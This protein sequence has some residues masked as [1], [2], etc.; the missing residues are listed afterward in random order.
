MKP[1]PRLLAL[2]IAA[3]AAA[4]E[5]VPEYVVAP[6]P[7]N[8]VKD[9]ATALLVDL[10]TPKA[11]ADFSAGSPGLGLE[12][13]RFLKEGG[14]RGPIAVPVPKVLDG[15]AWTIEMVMRA[16]PEA[17]A[18]GGAVALGGWA[19]KGGFSLGFA[20]PPHAGPGFTL[21][22]PARAGGRAHPFQFRAASGGSTYTLAKDAPGRWVYATFG[23]DLEGRRGSAMVRSLDGHV[24]NRNM[25][26]CG[27]GSLSEEFLQR[28]P[29]GER[30]SARD[31]CWQGMRDA[32]GAG[33]PSSFPLGGEKIDLRA[34]R[35]SRRFRPEVAL[36][37]P[38]FQQAEGEPLRASEIDAARAAK[39]RP[40]RSVGYNDHNLVTLPIEESWIP[41]APGQQVVLPPRKLP[42]GI[43]SWWLYGAVDPK[44]RKEIGRV[45]QP[46]PMEFEVKDGAGKKVGGGRLL[47][48]QSFSPRFMQAFSFHV[49]EPGEFTATLRLAERSMETVLLH[50]ANFVDVLKGV[51]DQAIKA[52]QLLAE[53]RGDRLKEL[54]EARKQ[55]DDA[56]WAA[57]PPLNTHTLA[58][59]PPIWR[60]LPDGAKVPD[61]SF[62]AWVGKRYPKLEDALAPM[63]LVDPAS[64]ASLPA[65]QVVAGAPL[66]GPLGD[67]GTGIFLRKAEHPSLAQDMYWCPRAALMCRR[68]EVL[69]R[70]I[71]PQNGQDG[72]RKYFETGD[73]E[74]GHDVAMLLVRFAYD[75][76]ALEYGSQDIRLCT[77]DKDLE[78]NQHWSYGRGGKV[79]NWSWSAGDAHD[80]IEAYDRVFPYIQDNALFA[81]E[82][83]RFIP[84]VKTPQDVVRLLDRQ[85]VLASV[86][87]ERR[88][89]LAT[90]RE[91]TDA[92]GEV[93][94]PGPLTADLFDLSTQASHLFPFRGPFADGYA[95]G[96]SRSG[97]YYAGSFLAYAL[98]S[99]KQTVAKA[100]SMLAL[101]RLGIAPRMDLSDADKFPKVRGAAN[102]ILGMWV[103][104]GFPCAVGDASG[105]PHAGRVAW[106]AID[107]ATVEKAFAVLGDP[108]Y[109]WILKNRF[110]SADPAAAKAAE[111]QRDPI[112]HAPSRVI[113]DYEAFLEATPD[114]A[115]P[116]RKVG[117]SLRLG[118]GRAHTHED[119]LDVN[120]WA[121]GVP[122][123]VDLACRN[124]GTSTWSRPSATWSF[125][126]NHAIATEDQDP[127]AAAAQD[128]EP[129][130]RA[131]APPLARAS[132]VNGKGTVS[133]DRDLCLVQVGDG[134][135]WYAFDFQR[136]K[137]L[138]LHTWCF[139]GCESE[140]LQLNVP[141]ED[142]TV[143]WVDRTLE[144]THKVG[145]ATDA[146]QATWTMTR[147]AREVPHKFGERGGGTI[148]AVACEPA[149][150]GDRYD[151]KL[152][153]VRMRATLLGRAGD[154]VL[155]GSPFSEF[156]QYCFPFLWVQG[157]AKGESVYPAVYEWY[158]GDA[159]TVAKAEILSPVGGAARAESAAVPWTVRVTTSSGQ[160]DEFT[161]TGAG[162]AAV[163]RDAKGGLRWA[164]LNGLAEFASGDLKVKAAAAQHSTTIA[165]VDYAKRRLVTKDPLPENPGVRV[166]NSSRWC[167]LQLKG[168]GTE[169]SW[170]DDLLIAQGALN[171]VKVTGPDRA[172]ID[173]ENPVMFA[174]AGN[175]KASAFTVCSEDLSWQFRDGK[176][177]R[178]PA[179][180][181]LSPAAFADADGDGVAKVKVFEVGVGDAI[182]LNADVEL[183]LAGGAWRAVANVPGEASV[184]GA[185]VAFAPALR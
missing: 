170:D 97:S 133:L 45:W 117:A 121:M 124:E 154:Q 142:K 75:W 135:A 112:A 92:A 23:L 56:I 98:G 31:E 4:S 111:G 73:P 148:K 14:Y 155:Q 10:S 44:G 63:D 2:A 67:D 16:P 82:V 95:V 28:L 106:N 141:M 162:F 88:G 43:Y 90:G 30:A 57:F 179:S 1:F 184:G 36:P 38:A 175:R 91:I 6:A 157:P 18:A 78:F 7:P 134:P 17:F 86:R 25:C 138:K 93:L 158:R 160:V 152:P 169:F 5:P 164:K 27:L 35:V 146:V 140:A 127:K 156:Y 172:E 22:A 76:P 128:G 159:P 143:R 40:P 83:H 181:A 85:L 65:D 84:W 60:K 94:G 74:L 66:P 180:A 167:W 108:R 153:P 139:H 151:A 103:A 173:A 101:K 87:D 46:A 47:L 26:W 109:A 145:A 183:K 107:R 69:E 42:V 33:L 137:G 8:L 130:L 53:G 174:G 55:R 147:E 24:L 13:G 58:A 113:P 3:S 81:G 116:L 176:V 34:V 79:I 54:T 150:L 126:H 178:K 163:S 114:E 168:K 166:G 70:F 80:M 161:V 171:E 11:Q 9:E 122:V 136:L 12:A 99:A 129:W 132:Y 96:M 19:E 64:G 50:Q 105:G 62:R 185:K 89:F 51:P 118:I 110:G 102:F 21:V 100:Y 29:E 59:P 182:F 41:L 72:A 149:V 120:F 61:W 49:D 39:G 52:K 20:I 144:G 37:T 68:L 115:D 123:A 119:F 104:G 15:P 48:K 177:V 131:F 125:L 32:W 77:H 71:L 165:D